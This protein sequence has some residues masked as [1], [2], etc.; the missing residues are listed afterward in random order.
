LRELQHGEIRRT[1][2]LAAEQRMLNDLV[3]G[4]ELRSPNSLGSVLAGSAEQPWCSLI[5]ADPKLLAGLNAVRSRQHDVL[6]A[7]DTGASS[8]RAADDR[9]I[10]M[11]PAVGDVGTEQRLAAIGAEYACCKQSC[12]RGEDRPL[13]R[14]DPV[15]NGSVQHTSLARAV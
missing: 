8:L 2:V 1:G 13:H 15:S 10:A 12:Y 6:R 4:A 11:N 5:S 3:D 9:R 7:R 14:R